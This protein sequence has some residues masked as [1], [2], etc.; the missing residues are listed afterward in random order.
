M[1]Y[2]DVIDELPDKRS[3]LV[4]A[5]SIVDTLLALKQNS[6]VTVERRSIACTARPDKIQ[7]N[8]AE[9]V[10][11]NT[12]AREWWT[13]LVESENEVSDSS[14]SP[15]ISSLPNP[16]AGNH[17]TDSQPPPSTLTLHVSTQ[18]TPPSLPHP[19]AGSHSSVDHPLSS[20]R[21]LSP[22]PLRS[23]HAHPPLDREVTLPRSQDRSLQASQ[24]QRQ[25]PRRQDRRIPPRQAR[26]G[27]ERGR[28][29]RS[30]D[31]EG[32]RQARCSRCHKHGHSEERCPARLVCEYC[33]GRYHTAQ[34]CRERLADR[35]HQDL[36][37]AVR[38][39]SQETLAILR[40]ATWRLPPQANWGA[41][42]THPQGPYTQH[43][44]HPQRGS[45]MPLMMPHGYSDVFQRQQ[46]MART[47]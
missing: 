22:H 45:F 46:R 21:A 16:P 24:R 5:L 11:D 19:T 7:K 10:R 13:S 31:H 40:G 8:W 47:L 42:T 2:S 9:H 14:T 17:S 41:P 15:D 32:T 30:E 44:A 3:V 26:A 35:R 39:G 36:I 29:D 28:G 6:S 20:P 25:P 43:P 1:A 33:Q 18:E 37:E 4:E 23:H 12:S 34:T 38:I 27:L